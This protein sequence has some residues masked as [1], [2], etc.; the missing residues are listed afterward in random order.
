MIGIHAFD[1]SGK[2]A[3]HAWLSV[4]IAEA[5]ATDLPKLGGLRVVDRTQL[6]KAFDEARLQE[7]TAVDASD[8]PRLGKMVG[9][10]ALVIGS[11]QIVGTQVRM[12]G[13]LVAV[14][15]G[16][17][18][19]AGEATGKLDDLFAI[20]RKLALDLLADYAGAAA[21]DKEAFFRSQAPPLE[22][23]AAVAEAD[24]ALRRGDRAAAKTALARAEKSDPKFASAYADLK[25]TAEATANV[26]VLPLTNAA[27]RA[28]EA[29][30]AGGIAESLAGDLRKLGVP[31]VERLAIDKLM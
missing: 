6:Q 23:L 15:S 26:A 13:R 14:D 19:R 20:E 10:D 7:L 5:L 8:A 11:F 27:G 17:V 2:S 21:K 12:L 3:P 24:A 18:I 29:W 28:D 30:L 9:A 16:T 22:G 31:Q 25:K 4:G 1:N